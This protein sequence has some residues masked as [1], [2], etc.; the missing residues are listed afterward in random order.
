[1]YEDV[2]S[3]EVKLRAKPHPRAQNK[4]PYFRYKPIT[5]YNIYSAMPSS[6]SLGMPFRHFVCMSS[7]IVVP[8]HLVVATKFGSKFCSVVRINPLIHETI[9]HFN[10]LNV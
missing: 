4:G 9:M 2:L 7:S 1:M 5:Y 6:L 8:C 3:P 10:R